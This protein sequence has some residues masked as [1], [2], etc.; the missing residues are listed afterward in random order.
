VTQGYSTI[1]APGEARLEVKKSQFLGLVAPVTSAAA[2]DA[3][4]ALRRKAHYSARHHCTALVLGPDGQTQRSNDD[5]EPAGSAGAPMLAVLRHAGVTDVVAVVTR[6]FGGT[7]LG[8]GGLIRAYTDAV[9]AAL[10]ATRIVRYE[11]AAIVKLTVPHAAAGEAD[12][13][14]RGWAAPRGGQ[15]GAPEYGEAVVFTLTLPEAQLGEL[16]EFWAAWI[17]RGGQLALAGEGFLEVG[18][19]T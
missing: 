4:I 13:A 8:V 17:G 6:Y 10:A 1:A 9:A 19:P 15:L 7:L 14:V 12:H 16:A 3:V 2:A 11:P 5:G 18:L